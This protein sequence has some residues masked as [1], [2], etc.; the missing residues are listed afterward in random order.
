MEQFCAM[1]DTKQT[2][3]MGTYGGLI[4]NN[5]LESTEGIIVLLDMVEHPQKWKD[6]IGLDPNDFPDGS[7]DP[8]NELHKPQNYKKIYQKLKD[9]VAAIPGFF[10]KSKWEQVFL[11]Q[12]LEAYP[13]LKDN[14][15]KL[16]EFSSILQKQNVF[17]F[18]KLLPTTPTLAI[19]NDP[20][21]LKN[22]NG[23]V[24]A[25]NGQYN[26]DQLAVLR[27]FFVSNM[28][29]LD[30]LDN[31][32]KA[33]LSNQMTFYRESQNRVT[34]FITKIKTDVEDVQWI[35]KSVLE[36]ISSPDEHSNN[37][38][39]S[40]RMLSELIDKLEKN[41]KSGII[42]HASIMEINQYL[43]KLTE[44]KSGFSL[45]KDKNEVLVSEFSKKWLQ[46]TSNL[47]K[48]LNADTSRVYSETH[49]SDID[50]SVLF[51]SRT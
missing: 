41:L 14:L 2:S 19:K 17:N 44:K 27:S 13:E 23:L 7:R 15:D 46:E 6:E 10:A 42:D 37:A 1:L 50:I 4:V 5:G 8:F 25:I 22:R 47:I 30:D 51:K 9:T 3:G 21:L 12:M 36:R 43:L 38:P 40:I 20:D 33:N 26:V 39:I 49:Q 35:P 24:L 11:I 45:F 34:D 16:V 18:I 29:N 32:N 28:N 48:H 31:M